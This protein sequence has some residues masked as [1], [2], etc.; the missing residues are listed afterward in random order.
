MDGEVVGDFVDGIVAEGGGVGTGFGEEGVSEDE[1]DAPVVAGAGR[2]D[3]VGWEGA[4]LH[5]V[6]CLFGVD[7][8]D[9]AEGEELVHRDVAGV[10]VLG[11]FLAPFIGTLAFFEP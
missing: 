8:I 5:F 2:V 10:G 3:E 6:G 1:I 4:E 7:E 9:E 11:R